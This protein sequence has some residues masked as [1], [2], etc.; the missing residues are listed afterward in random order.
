MYEAAK[1]DFQNLFAPETISDASRKADAIVAKNI[2]DKE[3]L[4]QALQKQTRNQFLFWE[5]VP[6]EMRLHAMDALETGAE[7]SFGKFNSQ[8]KD[9]FTQYRQRFD[10][11]FE[12]EKGMG[13]HINYVSNYFPHMWENP[14]AAQ[15]FFREYAQSLGKDKYAKER[16]IDLIKQGISAGLKLKTTNLE[17]VALKR[18]FDS[19]RM[20]AHQQTINDL[21]SMG[22]AR[23]YDPSARVPGEMVV[24]APNGKRYSVPPDVARVLQ[25]ALFSPSLWSNKGTVGVG[26]RGLMALK[27]MFVPIKLGLSLFHPVHIIGIDNAARAAVTIEKVADKTITWDQ[28]VKEGVNSFIHWTRPK[29]SQF[30]DAYDRY[31]VNDADMPDAMKQSVNNMIEGGFNPR[32]EG[33]WKTRATDSFKKALAD[34]NYPGAVI[35]GVPALLQA[36]QTPI[37]DKWIPALRAAQFD[38]RAKALFEGH[39]ELLDKPAE[40]AVELRK[41][42]KEVDNQYGEMNYSTL[43]WNRWLRD[44]GVGTS[45]SLG[46]NL[47]FLREFGGAAIDFA[48]AG[49]DLFAGNLS[50]ADLTNKMLFTTIYT[51]EA[52]GLG[53]LMTWAMTGKPPTQMLDYFYPR[54]GAKN[55]DG[56]DE[57]LSTPYYT[58]EYFMA[59][60]HIAK[61]GLVGG[62]TQLGVNKSNPVINPLIE[63][64]QNKDFYGY[65]INDPNAP[66]LQRAY[67]IAGYIG[68]QLLPISIGSGLQSHASEKA[69][70]ASFAGFNPAPRYITR[71]GM[72]SKIM[73]LY[74]ER[75][76][77][78]TKPY[79]QKQA[80]DARRNIL[81][82]VRGGNAQEA[83]QAI[84][85]AVQA[86]ILTTRQVQNIRRSDNEPTDVFMYKRLP[87][88]DKIALWDE[89][90]EEEKKR[91]PN[92]TQLTSNRRSVI[93]ARVKR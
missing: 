56:S 43:F 4:K 26:F 80:A 64:W 10:K 87:K 54:T 90:S 91:Y 93:R 65:Q 2:Q 29:G 59:T 33:V 40:R 53:G 30:L 86:G 81:N 78:G 67:Q 85:N 77:G 61:E 45:L 14:E 52:M 68:K 31:R 16:T 76:G 27:N 66:A 18:D 11:D 13:I 7:P 21:E 58:R 17:E 42:G 36:M 74:E 9:L 60:D 5:S 41:I 24:D 20:L 15:Q 72:Q 57:R 47:G 55:D 73:N 62:L 12:N 92:P 50:R 82:L 35:R 38:F 49:K 37:F 1:R 48:K 69:R 84:Q 25:N 71:T 32:R 46:W 34:G 19:A 23:Q 44:V 39:P 51:A 88:S 22:L 28:G 70:I 3:Q 79:S 83:D 63:L 6:E 8:V 75:F 89:M